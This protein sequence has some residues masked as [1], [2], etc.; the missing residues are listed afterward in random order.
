MENV[1]NSLLMES[2]NGKADFK[3]TYKV[4]RIIYSHGKNK[5]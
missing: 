2:T 1:F 5:C 3:K 4:D